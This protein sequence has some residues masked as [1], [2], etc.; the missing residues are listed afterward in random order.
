MVLIFLAVVCGHAMGAGRI[1]LASLEWPPYTGADLPG[2]G[3]TAEVV[4][5]ACEA[6]GYELEIRFY[7]WTRVLYEASL[8]PEIAGYFPEYPENLRR[9]RFLQSD[10]IGTSPLGLVTRS[11]VVIRWDTP[12]DLSKYRLGIVA[13]YANTPDFDELVERGV[14]TVDLSNSDALN[15]RKVL[16]GRVSAAVVDT[17]VFARLQ[18]LDPVLSQACDELAVNDRLLA[19]NE[20]VVCFRATEAGAH[21]RD[22]FNAGLARVRQK[23]IYQRHFG[24]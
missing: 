6:A 14:L 21:L 9:G 3:A 8:D 22:E 20:L 17:N 12:E 16:A 10:S 19:V 1:V 24:E 11:E 2:E 5:K 18:R 15:L 13:G 4:R 23:D 7:P